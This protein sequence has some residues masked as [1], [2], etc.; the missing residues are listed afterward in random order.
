MSQFNHVAFETTQELNHWL[1]ISAFVFFCVFVVMSGFVIFPIVMGVQRNK[2]MILSIY[3]DLPM[4]EIKA[5]HHRCYQ[6]LCK[7]D[8]ERR[9]EAILIAQQEGAEHDMMKEEGKEDSAIDASALDAD[10]S[11]MEINTKREGD[12]SRFTDRQLVQVSNL[13]SKAHRKKKKS[14]KSLETSQQQ[15]ITEKTKKDMDDVNEVK[16]SQEGQQDGENHEGE[17]QGEDGEQALDHNKMLKDIKVSNNKLNMITLSVI[18][19]FLTYFSTCF[20]ISLNYL[21]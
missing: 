11:A 1:L 20:G 6:F 10:S 8:D 15:R 17:G 13:K 5:V 21:G 4:S 7:M 14:Q 9:N 3:F 16:S 12:T 18:V 2:V 19:V